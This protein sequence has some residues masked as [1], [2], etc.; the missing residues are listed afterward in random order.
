MQTA[1]SSSGTKPAQLTR[2]SRKRNHPRP[3]GKQRPGRPGISMPDKVEGWGGVRGWGGGV[4]AAPRANGPCC[5]QLH[6]RVHISMCRMFGES[7]PALH[8]RARQA[9]QQ[10]GN[11]PCSSAVRD[12]HISR[13][14]DQLKLNVPLKLLCWVGPSRAAR[15]PSLGT[16]A[17]CDWP[18]AWL[19]CGSFAI[20]SS[21]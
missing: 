1:G 6:Q 8:S 4:G 21:I 17:V 11:F 7:G 12:L 3:S 14:E 18:A 19:T 9:G 16:E 20:T 2:R 15:G 13:T 5:F 10:R